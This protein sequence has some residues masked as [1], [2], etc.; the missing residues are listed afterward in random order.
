MNAP[1]FWRRTAPTSAKARLIAAAT[2][3]IFAALA[4]ALVYAPLETRLAEAREKATSLDRRAAALN[5]AAAA[6]LT[7]AAVTSPDADALARATAWLGEH[8]PLR[9]EGE[10]ELELLSTLRLLAQAAEVDLASV[11]SLDAARDAAARDL[12]AQAGV[13]GLSA[14]VAEARIAADHAGLARFLAALEAT[15]PTLRATALEITARSAN[16]AAE[17]GRLSVRVVVAALSRPAEG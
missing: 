8:A 2:V 6:R 1:P 10:A 17:S 5:A 4:Y 9:S 13:A 15:R 14:H 3:A 12:V 7:E 11:T 16:A